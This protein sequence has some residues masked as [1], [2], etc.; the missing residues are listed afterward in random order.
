[1]HNKSIM[2]KICFTPFLLILLFGL[3]I[4]PQHSE[5]ISLLQQDGNVSKLDGSISAIVNTDSFS[6]G[7][8]GIYIQRLKDHTTLFAL[9]QDR[10]FLPASNNKILTSAFALQTLGPDF[11]YHT[12]VKRSGIMVSNGTLRGNLILVGSGNPILSFKDI[13]DMAKQVKESGI[14]RIYGNIDYDDSLFD[15][16]RLGDTWAWDDEPYYYSAQISAL[17]LNENMIEVRAFPGKK[18]GLPLRGA[19][20]PD[21]GYVKL[22]VSA[23]TGAAKSLNSVYFGRVRGRNIITIAGSIPISTLT[24][25]APKAPITIENPSRY[26][27]DYLVYCLHK[28]GVIIRDSAGPSPLVPPKGSVNVAQNVSPPLSTILR[29]M[30]KP[31][32][33]L[34]AECLMKTAAAKISGVGTGGEGGTGV[35]DA[36]AVLLKI[37]LIPGELHQSDGSGLSRTN[38]ISPRNFIRT[39]TFLYKSPNF[40]IF[41]V[42]LPIAG[43]DGSMRRRLTDTLAANNCHAKTGYVSQVNTVSGY[44]TD[45]DG[46]MIVF[47]ILF[48][49]MLAPYNACTGAQD[50]IIE[51]LAEYS[52]KEPH[53]AP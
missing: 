13:Q 22:K 34:L 6:T 25:N 7:F 29:L 11:S 12:Y 40:H 49:N 45:K 16:Q 31:S 46:D 20:Y 9:N 21:I 39:L 43:V 35:Q 51:L 10:V 33:N 23:V 28:D 15:R 27:A 14:H 5:G 37:G 19:L 17:N 41:Y 18:E 42:S 30:N 52:D 53:N 48:N 32:D 26:A 2:K 24:K 47:S 4:A 44:V 50:K 38:F 3:I 8:A 1:M 36:R